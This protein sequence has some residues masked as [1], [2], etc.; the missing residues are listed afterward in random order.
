MR[1][2]VNIERKIFTQTVNL[3]KFNPLFKVLSNTEEYI[4]SA[5]ATHG[6]E[7]TKIGS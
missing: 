6:L 4:S 2:L 5:G 7:Q 3:Q 1:E